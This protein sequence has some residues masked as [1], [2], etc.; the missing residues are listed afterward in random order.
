M[1]RVGDRVW[2]VN[3]PNLNLLGKREPR[4]TGEPGW[5]TCSGCATRSAAELGLVVELRQSNHEG[6]LVDWLQQAGAA[7][8]AGELLG[9]V[10]NPGAYGHTSIALRD[11][12]VG[13][14]LTVVE[15]HVSN[16]HAR[17]EFRRHSYVSAVAAGVI[18]GLGVAGYPLAAAG[19]GQSVDA[20]PA[21]IPPATPTTG[22][23]G[24]V[25]GG[26]AVRR[27][28]ISRAASRNPSA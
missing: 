20:R 3:G 7:Q 21:L 2:V 16:V 15:V 5:P 25:T 9:V 11:A 14:G 27:S 23:V 12:I 8:D 19:A 10:L 28:M 13:S 17:E 6:E 4:S 1:A 26:V 22:P 18:V 24:S